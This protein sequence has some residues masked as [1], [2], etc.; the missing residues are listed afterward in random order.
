[1]FQ[2]MRLR[3]RFGPKVKEATRGCRKLGFMKN[4]INS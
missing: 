3:R 2:N 4:F 1:M